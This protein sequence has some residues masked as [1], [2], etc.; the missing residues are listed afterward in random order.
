MYRKEH[1]EGLPNQRPFSELLE[2]QLMHMEYEKVLQE[3]RTKL[4]MKDVKH[5]HTSHE[6]IG[7]ED[8]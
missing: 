3:E 6:R 5:T 8:L 2:A 4:G 1:P 7:E